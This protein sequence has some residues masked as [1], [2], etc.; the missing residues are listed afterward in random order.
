[1]TVALF[2]S[3]KIVNSLDNYIRLGIEYVLS[4]NEI[5]RFGAVCTKPG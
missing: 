2:L 3:L 1:M 5:K 4:R